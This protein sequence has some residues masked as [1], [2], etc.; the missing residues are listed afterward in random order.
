MFSVI[1]MIAT[2]SFLTLHHIIGSLTFEFKSSTDFETEYS[3]FTDGL[4]LGHLINVQENVQTSMACL[5][6]CKTTLGCKFASFH[7]VAFT[8]TLSKACRKVVLTN[9]YYEHSSV[10]CNEP[11]LTTESTT[12][13]ETT[14]PIPDP[15]TPDDPTTPEPKPDKDKII[16]VGGFVQN[17]EPDPMVEI[18]D[19]ETQ[20]SCHEDVGFTNHELSGAVSGFVNGI[21]TICAGHLAGAGISQDC[22]QYHI[23][24]H[25]F[26]KSDQLFV[27]EAVEAA[28][29]AQ[30]QNETI[31]MVGGKRNESYQISD[32]IQIVGQTQ[33]WRLDIGSI[34]YSCLVHLDND[35]YLLIG[36]RVGYMDT[37]RTYVFK[38]EANGDLYWKEGPRL[39]S[40]RSEHMCGMMQTE[41][42]RFIVT[43][44]GS[45]TLERQCEYLEI[46][47]EGTLQTWQQC[48]GLPNNDM[49]YG[50]TVIA[51]PVK[52]GL[53]L[54]GGRNSTKEQDSIYTFSDINGEWTLQ[55]NRLQG[56]RQKHVSIL[57]SNVPNDSCENVLKV[58]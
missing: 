14:T 22:Y 58:V 24:S 15:T 17:G 54:L 26:N 34:S 41:N 37:S 49:L 25:S 35:T 31:M 1:K 52:G 11:V 42:K 10:Q 36:G 12:S 20:Q 56:S 9:Q 27:T 7:N 13:Q 48:S 47:T 28:A 18:V 43:I 39:T 46:D 30:W 21:P 8:C 23:G 55:F 57:M 32:L 2:F 45:S 29:Y 6:Q 38:P 51:D 4:C 5:D 19:L 53:L 40:K 44:G 3:C 33:F 50:A 16:I